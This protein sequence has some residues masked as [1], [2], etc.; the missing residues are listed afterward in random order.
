M[1]RVNLNGIYELQLTLP[2]TTTTSV[3]SPGVV[4]I[5]NTYSGIGIGGVNAQTGTS[6]IIQ[7]S[8]LNKLVTISNAAAVAVTLPSA[9]TAGFG[10]PFAFW[11]ENTGVGTV[12][13][14]PTTSTIDRAASLALNQNQ[15]VMIFSD[16]TNYFTQRGIGTGGGGSGITALTGDV[17]ATGPGSAPATLATTAVTPGSYTNAAK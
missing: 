10:N 1:N 2:G 4:S 3:P 5:I 17:T 14:T 9:M 8:D 11:I 16:G 7:T 13:I 12:T 15:G 6:Y